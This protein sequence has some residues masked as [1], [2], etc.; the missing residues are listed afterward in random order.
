M[1]TF[2][3]QQAKR[4]MDEVI[5]LLK[6]LRKLHANESDKRKKKQLKNKIKKLQDSLPNLKRTIYENSKNPE[7]DK[8]EQYR[9]EKRLNMALDKERD[10]NYLNE[11]RVAT[12]Y[13]RDDFEIEKK[14]CSSCGTPINYL[15]G[16][17][18]CK[19]N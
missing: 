1:S 6:K 14:V 15:Y 11:K 5:T 3:A 8:L 16:F 9:K 4:K 13:V 10:L 17:S 2:K 12:S 19:C 7:K 18:R